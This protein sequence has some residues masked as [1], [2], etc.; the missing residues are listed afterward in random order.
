MQYRTCIGY[1]FI[2]PDQSAPIPKRGLE[3][4]AS[5]VG[6]LLIP[7]RLNVSNSSQSL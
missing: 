6:F 5:N 4:L 1:R 2:A 3:I 7:D